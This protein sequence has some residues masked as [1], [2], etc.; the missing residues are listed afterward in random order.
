MVPILAPVSIN[1]DWTY[2]RGVET[3]MDQA[4]ILLPDVSAAVNPFQILWAGLFSLLFGT[5]LGVFRLSTFILVLLSAPAFYGICREL[6]LNRNLALLGTALY[7]FNPIYFSLAYT[8]MTDPH[9][10][11]LVVIS[12]FFYLRGLNTQS[13]WSVLCGSAVAACAILV[14]QH[15]I[16][17][18]IA[19][20]IY[21]YTSRNL[22]F[23]I[24]SLKVAVQV[25][26]VPVIA[27]IGSLLWLSLIHGVPAGTRDHSRDIVEAPFAER[28]H[29]LWRMTF[30]TLMYLGLFVAPL[31]ASIAPRAASLIRSLSSKGLIAIGLWLAIL[32]GGLVDFARQGRLMPYLPDG[33]NR[34]GIGATDLLGSRPAIAD[35]RSLLIFTVLVAMFSV[36][37]VIAAASISDSDDSGKLGA[38][39]LLSVA[40]W[41]ALVLFIV[42]HWF[43]RFPPDRPLI[44]VDRYVVVLLPF[45]ICLFAWRIR[46]TQFSLV[47]AWVATVLIGVFSVAGTRDSVVFHQAVWEVAADVTKMGIPETKLD[48]G[49]AWDGYHVSDGSRFERQSRTPNPPPWI[50]M[51]APDIDSTYLISTSPVDGYAVFRAFE[52]SQWLQPETTHLYLSQR[53]EPPATPG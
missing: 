19:V 9:F 37:L 3:L 4:R 40:G 26:G 22:R 27:V 30:I 6:G 41:Q 31:A 25:L 45:A 42:S 48:A 43:R 52:Y 29:L 7:L 47:T 36:I 16:L 33:L 50:P 18:P 34:H 5:H 12:L 28:V 23:D 13:M 46:K 53:V 35:D 49:A 10:I 14:R 21:L 15:G 51:F 11:S 44:S 20:V 32:L 17:I 38:G 24:K 2:A 1:D 39:M 8:F